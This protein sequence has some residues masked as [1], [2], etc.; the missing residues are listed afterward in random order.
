MD[1]QRGYKK[2]SAFLL[3]FYYEMIT[4]AAVIN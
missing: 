3:D 2:L 1:L 4:F